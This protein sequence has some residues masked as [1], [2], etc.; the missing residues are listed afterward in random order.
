MQVLEGL[1][2]MHHIGV[3]EDRSKNRIEYDHS[4]SV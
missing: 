2:I 4:D 1:E 3:L